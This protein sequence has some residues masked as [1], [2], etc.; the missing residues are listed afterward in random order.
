MDRPPHDPDAAAC[1]CFGCHIRS[2]QWSPAAT[3]TRR[4]AIPGKRGDNAWERGVPTDNRGMPLLDNTLNPVGQK[5]Y[6]ANRSTIEAKRRD[7]H[8]A[9]AQQSNP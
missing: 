1:D 8:N 6:A 2:V 3:P 9:A 7:L 5:K 4:N